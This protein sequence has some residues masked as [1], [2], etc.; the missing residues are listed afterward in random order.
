MA[1]QRA[2]EPLLRKGTRDPLRSTELDAKKPILVL[3]SV[4][5][6]YSQPVL[7]NVD[8]SIE[9]GEFV[10]IT[11]PSGSGKSTFLKLVY[12]AE[13]VD[14]GRVLFLGRDIARL[15][16]Q[17]I[18]FLRRNMG[19]VFQDFKVI[20]PWS[21][22][23]NVAIPLEI[24][25]QSSR[26]IR[27]RVLLALDRVGLSDKINQPVGVLSGGEQ[28]RVAIARA[29]VGEPPILL[30]DEPTGNLDPALAFDILGL[31][32]EISQAGT[33]VLFAT[34]DRSLLD[35]QPAR[36]LVIDEGQIFDAKDGLAGDHVP[37]FPVEPSDVRT[38]ARI[39]DEC[40]RRVS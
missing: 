25:G 26:I 21:V 18:P 1:I 4:S 14:E 24:V 10:F 15:T 2:F 31:F 7:V 19:I 29:I 40:I 3:D 23:D 20:A 38:K 36:I 6:S 32:A 22:Y 37:G 30:A 28:Q 13:T 39:N 12:R 35:A 27:Q 11:G 9:C 33:T 17:S 8:L 16:E 34:H 5:K